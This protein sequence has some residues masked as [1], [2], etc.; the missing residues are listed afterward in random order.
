MTL[1][2]SFNAGDSSMTTDD[3]KVL[4]RLYILE[5]MVT[6]LREEPSKIEEYEPQRSGQNENKGN[7]VTISI[8]KSLSVSQVLL[9]VGILS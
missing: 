4:H 5:E 1:E 8:I 9:N 3:M 2:H 6:T 7:I